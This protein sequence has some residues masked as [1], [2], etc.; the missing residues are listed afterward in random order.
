MLASGRD[1]MDCLPTGYGK[2]KVCQ[3]WQFVYTVDQGETLTIGQLCYGFS[4][5]PSSG[6]EINGQRHH[7]CCGFTGQVVS[8]KDPLHVKRVSRHD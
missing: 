3:C 1:V 5:Q 7:V 2:S 6:S 8:S 4:Y